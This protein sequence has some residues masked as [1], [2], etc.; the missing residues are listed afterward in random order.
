MERPFMFL[1]RLGPGEVIGRSRFGSE[2]D[3][4]AMPDRPPME[5]GAKL[6][7]CA[8]LTGESGD[9][10]GEGSERSDESAVDKVVVG[11]ES[12]D[13]VVWV[14]VLSLCLWMD[15]DGMAPGCIPGCEAPS[16]FV[17]S[18]TNLVLTIV[19]GFDWSMSPIPLSTW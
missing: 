10:D 7:S 1:S 18:M 3:R 16:T 2:T 14:D 4:R 19:T 15:S 11:D 6:G 12:A 9:E 8:A 5:V 17:S 13:S